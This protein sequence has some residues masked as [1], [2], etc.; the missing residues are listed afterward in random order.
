ML[1]F[2]IYASLG[3][4]L[5]LAA[6]GA[7]NAQTSNGFSDAA[8][9]AQTAGIPVQVDG[10]VGAV[11]GAP[12]AAAV[13][14]AMPTSV[15]GK[16]AQYKPCD[17]YTECPGDH[18]V[19]TFGPPDWRSAYAH[20]PALAVNVADWVGDYRPAPNNVAVKVALFQGGTVVASASGQVDANGPDD[21]AFR[22]LIASMSGKVLS[23]PDVFD[24][25]GLP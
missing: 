9:G 18:V 14:A 16:P 17:P 13:A 5:A 7:Y 19:W 1:Q 21:P 6:C 3:L 23:G 22:S 4:C 8:L 20:P 12:L 2:R 25:L 10:S 15:E 11:R 24:W